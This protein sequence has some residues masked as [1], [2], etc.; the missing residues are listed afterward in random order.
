MPV[1]DSESEIDLA[2][3]T[4]KLK[5][6]FTEVLSKWKLVVLVGVIGVALGLLYGFMKKPLYVAETRVLNQRV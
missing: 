3:A 4:K 2:V 6:Y 1:Q 5:G